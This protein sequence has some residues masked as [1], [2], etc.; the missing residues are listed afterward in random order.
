MKTYK[1]TN[2]K[3]MSEKEV[4]AANKRQMDIFNKV[5]SAQAGKCD[6][7]KLLDFEFFLP[8]EICI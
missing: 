7:S 5:F 1:C 4:A 8:A 3:K 2:G 6:Y